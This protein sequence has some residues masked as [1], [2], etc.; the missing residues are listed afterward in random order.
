MHEDGIGMARTFEAE[1]ARPGRTTP[2]GVASRVLRAGSTARP[3]EGYRPYR[4][5]PGRRRPAAARRS[6]P[7]G[8]G[9]RS[10]PAS[11]AR[12]VLAP[13]VARLGRDDVRVV[14]VRNRLLRRQHRRAPGSWSATTGR[15]C[16]PTEPEG[17]RYLL[18]DVCLS[19]GRFLDGTTPG[20]LP[21]PVEI[22]ATDGVALRAA[23]ERG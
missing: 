21:R 18:P 5:A 7:R 17:H 23:L 6:P 2:I 22:V 8:A 19:K 15:A 11:T 10:S 16:W 4:G 20:D 3:A 1:L 9:R 14:P 12:R 13:L